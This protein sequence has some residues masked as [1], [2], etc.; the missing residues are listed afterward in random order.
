MKPRIVVTQGDLGGIAPEVLLHC[1]AQQV[2][3]DSCL[4]LVLGH[5]NY[6]QQVA[7]HEA[8]DIELRAVDSASSGFALAEECP[9]VL[10]VLELTSPQPTARIGVAHSQFGAAAVEAVAHATKL[11]LSGAAEAMLTPPVNKESMHLAGFD[12]E[13]QT[14]LIGETCNSDSY[15]MLACAGELKVWIATRHMSLS[16][17][18]S[19]LTVDY[20]LEQIRIAHVAA[21]EVLGI[22][23]PRVAIAALNPH[24]GENGA[25]GIEEQT[26][27]QPAIDQAEQKFGLTTI[28]PLVPDVIFDAGAQGKYD[29]VIALYHDQAFIP[30]KMLPREKANSLFVGADVLRISP[31]HGSA[32][33][34]ARQ[35]KADARPLLYCLQQ[36]VRLVEQR[37]LATMV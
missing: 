18:I 37:R 16:N 25:F 27:I 33:D 7:E 8:I 19:T 11:C 34:I 1:L 14:Q 22:E 28:G 32:Y 13:G 29:I 31:M 35:Q 6:L 3:R 10:P 4:P 15:G 21:R 36:A 9:T 23:N 17:A 24:A 30:L 12:Y 26:I 2:A 20:L 5:I